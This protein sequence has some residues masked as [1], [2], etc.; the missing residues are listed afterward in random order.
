VRIG[1]DASCWVNERGYG[2]FTREL[3][4]AM[5]NAAPSDY[6]VCFMDPTTAERFD[7]VAANVE[8]VEVQSRV[9]PTRAAAARSRRS[10]LDMLRFSRAVVANEIDVFW[11]PAEYT[12]FPLP[13]AMRLVV[14]VHDTIATRYP[15]LALS[16]PRDRVFWEAKVRLAIWQADLILTVSEYS[17]RQIRDVFRVAPGRIRVAVEAPAAIYTPSERREDTEAA[18]AR[19]GV[20]SGSRWFIY[21]GGFN[22]HKHVEVV[23][24]AH[25][26]IAAESAGAPPHLLMVGPTI[27]DV[28]HADRRRVQEEIERTGTSDLVHWTGFVA[29][30]ELRHLLSG[31]IALVFPSQLEGFGLPAVEAAACG[32]PVIATRASPLPEL[33]EDG[34]IFVEPGSETD[35][36]AAMRFM[37]ADEESRAAMG[38]RARACA[39]RL[40]WR[41][42]A[43]SALKALHEA[44]A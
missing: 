4:R 12:F 1:V 34:G 13:P 26:A 33:L 37:L 42:A 21:L 6:F 38:V 28:F 40:S 24:R 20:P 35:V 25:A 15:H 22:P 7:L 3:L 23:V 18:A 31:A 44:A 32:T 29:D 10:L 5:A 8:I 16:G 11:C 36:A 41:D 17:A 9:P 27:E 39:G 2:R 43:R 30:E 14:T 19:A